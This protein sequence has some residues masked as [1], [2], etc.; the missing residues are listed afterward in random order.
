M[1]QLIY[2]EDHIVL[3]SERITTGKD[4]VFG[5]VTTF[6]DV[7]VASEM[8]QPYDDGKA[9]KHRDELEAYA[10]TVSG[11]WAIAG[12][13]PEAAIISDRSQVS[14]RTVNPRFVKNLKDPKTGRPNRAGVVADLEV[15]D[16]HIDAKLLAEMKKG[17]KTDVSIG[18]FYTADKTAGA[19]EDGPFKGE[20]YDYVQRNMFH[21]HLAI[22]ID[23]G[24]CP[25]PYCGLTADQI[26][27]K[28]A[29]DPFSGFPDWTACIAGIGKENPKMPKGEVEGICGKLKANHEKGKKDANMNKTLQQLI[30]EVQAMR[31]EQDARTFKEAPEW[32]KNLDWTKAENKSAFDTLSDETRKLIKDAGLC[33]FC[34]DEAAKKVSKDASM[35]QIDARIAEL[36]KRQS[37]LSAQLRGLEKRL[38][39]EV[40]EEKA[41]RDEVRKQIDPIWDELNNVSTEL[42]IYTQA[43]V[44]ALTASIMPDAKPSGELRDD[45]DEVVAPHLGKDEVLTS[46]QRGELP[47]D[48]FAYVDPS[49]EKK[50]GKMPES[51]RHMPIENEAHVKAALAALEGARSGKVPPYADKAKPKVCAAAKKMGIES[52]VCGAEKKEGAKP[53][54]KPKED[55][56]DPEAVLAWSRKLTSKRQ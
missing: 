52:T 45:Y 14:G 4:E 24:R 7:V 34:L 10:W 36:R 21:D 26:N 15:F 27:E 35:E 43:K 28:V 30:D 2:G 50:D 6:H 13:H 48:A 19:V 46:K 11:R 37:D 20:K 51:C 17:K 12:G 9:L 39:D 42:H 38:F 56:L 1:T 40:P 31:G 49:C 18:F 55:A 5:P 53:E 44:M 47:D 25:S 23:N 41:R 54:E 33:P 29:A 32:W 3:D 22:G 16:K 8:V